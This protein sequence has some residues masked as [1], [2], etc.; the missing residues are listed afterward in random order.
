MPPYRSSISNALFSW[1][2]QHGAERL[3]LLVGVES[4]A[5]DHGAVG[6]NSVRRPQD[7]PG[8]HGH[9]RLAERLL[10]VLHP[11][12]GR[13]AEGMIRG[14]RTRRE[15]RSYGYRAVVGDAV[16]DAHRA[17]ERAEVAHPAGGGP[18]ERAPEVVLVARLPDHDRPAGRGVLADAL[19]ARGD[20]EILQPG[21]RRPA[22]GWEKLRRLILRERDRE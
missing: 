22:E 3:P 12:P 10:Q 18:A 15:R 14:A 2:R 17:A 7:P 8:R 11:V 5:D 20:A 19:G 6:G 9:A 21:R 1:Q 13:P 4:G 16:G